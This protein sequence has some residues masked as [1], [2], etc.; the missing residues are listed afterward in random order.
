MRLVW[1]RWR[2]DLLGD[3]AP[4]FPGERG[5]NFPSGVTAKLRGGFAFLNMLPL[6]ADDAD[7]RSVDGGRVGESG[8]NIELRCGAKIDDYIPADETV[9]DDEARVSAGKPIGVQLADLQV[10]ALL[11]AETVGTA[12]ANF[13]D[14]RCKLSP[15]GPFGSWARLASHRKGLQWY[16]SHGHT[17]CT[18]LTVHLP[19][20]AC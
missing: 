10:G 8:D 12:I 17:Q 2:E 20:V 4:I 19:S 15:L 14:A 13:D 1:H 3:G 11:D 6:S 9:A 7:H 18:A 16:T 5:D